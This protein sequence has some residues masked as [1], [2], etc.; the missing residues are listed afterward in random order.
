[1]RLDVEPVVIRKH[2]R[3]R[4]YSHFGAFTVD[5]AAGINGKD[6]DPL[7]VIQHIII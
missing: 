3:F 1:M 2:I 6:P 5:L 7:P 4:A